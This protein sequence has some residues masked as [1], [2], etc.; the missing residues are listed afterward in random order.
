M[1]DKIHEFDL[2][3][4]WE[5]V[6]P[7]DCAMIITLKW[8]YKVKLDEYGDVL[9]NKARLVAKGYRLQ[10]SPNPRGIF[11]NQS[12][13]ANEILKKYDLQKSDP[14]DTPMLERTKLDD[15]LSGIPVDQTQ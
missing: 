2:L 9:K 12:K 1:Q 15:D 7:P 6:P 11:I 10:I 5:L 3:D 8:I 13:Y 4:V 14:V